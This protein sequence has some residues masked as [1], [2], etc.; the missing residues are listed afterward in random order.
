VRTAV[1]L[2]TR[3]LR[4]HDNP[5]LAAA[6]SGARQVV[7]LFVL[8]PAIAAA[9]NR[10]RF[11]AES[12]SDLRQ[13]L[14]QR[15]GDLV[16]R[17]GDPVAET[18]RLARSVE[19]DA[20]TVAAD[21][22]AYARRREQRLRQ[23]CQSSR[24]SLQILPGLTVVPPGQIAPSGGGAA[25]R[26]FTP[27]WRIWRDQPWRAPAPTPRRITMP[28]GVDPGQLPEPPV[29]GLSPDVVP[30][31]EAPARRRL[32]AWLHDLDGYAANHDLMAENGTS[33]L[34][35]YLRFGCLSPLEVGRA[36]LDTGADAAE[37]FI[38]QLCWRDFYHQ[39]T[40]AFPQITSEPVR[41]VRENWKGDSDALDAW[42][43]G[44][45]GVPIVDAGMRQL[46]AEGWMHNRARLLVGS[47]LTKHLGLDW[48]DGGDWF[49]AWL[50]DG[51][52]ANNYGN[53]QWVAGTGN[54]TRPHRRFNPI[55]QALRFDPDGTY[56]R[57]YVE[58]LSDVAGKAVHEPW[59]LPAA[60]R[61]GYPDRV[62]APALDEWL[63]SRA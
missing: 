23:A 38:R 18:V 26:I 30:G 42:Q 7:A 10:H 34:S 13:A 8:D 35:S 61:G 27:Y 44:R 14:R 47:Y 3:D 2:F 52:V 5:A 62:P 46:M 32:T 56:V 60:Q 1:A 39:M 36:A 31:G 49:S 19:A 29:S 63:P 11:L 40:Y 58:E 15:G 24:L 37:D 9:P 28:A 45:I 50:L 21:V 4:V 16:I 12:L 6:V 55:R 54:D 51:D 17:R 41:P 53:W 59:N 22:S 43:L 57:R 33:R 20:V 25:Y 48:R